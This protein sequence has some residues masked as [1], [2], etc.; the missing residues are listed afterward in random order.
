V[1]GLSGRSIFLHSSFRPFADFFFSLIRAIGTSRAMEYI[2]TGR[3]FSAADA[4]S[5]GLVSRVVPDEEGQAKG[6][7]VLAEAMKV[8]EEI[9]GKGRLSVL[10]AKEAI[11]MGESS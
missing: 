5:W 4:A 1:E 9:A 2:L 10:A 7:G 3:Q 6:E 11:K 8:A